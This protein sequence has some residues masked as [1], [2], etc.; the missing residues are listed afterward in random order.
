M[1]GAF[2]DGSDDTICIAVFFVE[3]N[4]LLSLAAPL[5]HGVCFYHVARSF[6][7]KEDICLHNMES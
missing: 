5:P 4:F 6:V 7:D 1:D 3:F 2:H